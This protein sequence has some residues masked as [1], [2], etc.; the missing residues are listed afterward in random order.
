MLGKFRG[1]IKIL[2]THN[3]LLEICS[4]SV[5]ILSEIFSV[6]KLQLPAYFF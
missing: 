5:K 2:S 3:L 4:L 1:K 6:R